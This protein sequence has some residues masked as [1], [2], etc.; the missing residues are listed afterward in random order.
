MRVIA[1]V[2]L[3]I[4]AIYALQNIVID[5]INQ[6]GDKFIRCQNNRLIV[7]SDRKEIMLRGFVSSGFSYYTPGFPVKVDEELYSELTK[8][9]LNTVRISLSYDLFY[10]SDS[11]NQYK[12]S[13]WDWIN[14]HIILAKKY[15]VYLI[16]QMTQIEGAQFTPIPNIPFDYRIWSNTDIQNNFISLW[17]EIAERYYNEEHIAGYSLF[18]EPVC[19]E[20]VNQWADLANRAIK[21]IREVDKNHII[22]I[23]RAYGEDEVRRELTEE[24]IIPV[25]AFFKINDKNIVYEFYY[26]ETDDYTH[27]FASWRPELQ[28]N[29]SY[30]D[31]KTIIRYHEK[32]GEKDEFS[33]DKDYLEF[34]LKKQIEFGSRENVPI[35]VWGF[36][37]TQNCYR[38]ENGGI[39]WMKDVID[40][41]NKYHLNWTVFYNSPFFG[42]KDNKGVKEVIQNSIQKDKKSL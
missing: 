16:L 9:N 7:G 28:K 15:N 36:G 23:E 25:D 39:Q 41:F 31:P 30:P 12:S 4:L 5:A 3:C 42:I 38:N 40:L 24:E 10:D 19:S 1:Y 37:L 27:Q 11:P 32:N 22:F 13:I 18:C 29:E 17:T 35:S 14:F 20:T 6:S 21:K 8:L 26:F 2:L 34:Y 33:F